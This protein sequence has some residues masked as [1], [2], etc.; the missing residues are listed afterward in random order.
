MLML[1]RLVINIGLWGLYKQNVKH[2]LYM[3]ILTVSLCSRRP[4]SYTNYKEFKP[5]TV[6]LLKLWRV[7]I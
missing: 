2:L 3:V 5:A 7:S 4:E 6:I 1:I